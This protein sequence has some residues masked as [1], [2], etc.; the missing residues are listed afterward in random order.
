M[1][2]TL[3]KDRFVAACLLATALV[4]DELRWFR[5][6]SSKQLKNRVAFTELCEKY[7]VDPKAPNPIAQL[8]LNMM[9]EQ[10]RPLHPLTDQQVD[11]FLR[12]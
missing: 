7:A 9:S 1:S 6:F 10:A 12:S 11:A 5:A 4:R 3:S 8:E 2:K